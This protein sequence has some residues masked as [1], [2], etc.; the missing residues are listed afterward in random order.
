[1]RWSSYRLLSLGALDTI[2][3]RAGGFGVIPFG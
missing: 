3:R 2:V 1:L